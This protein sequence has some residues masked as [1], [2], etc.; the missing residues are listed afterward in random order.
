M[1]LIKVYACNKLVNM[2][3]LQHINFGYQVVDDNII[4]ITITT[5]IILHQT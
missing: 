3:H 4:S 5:I 1:V 2:I